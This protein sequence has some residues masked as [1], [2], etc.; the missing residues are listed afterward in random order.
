MDRSTRHP[1]ARTALAS[2][3]TSLTVRPLRSIPVAHLHV[4]FF[5]A[6]ISKDLSLRTPI[7]VARFIIDKLRAVILGTHPAPFI[8]TLPLAR[9]IHTGPDELDTPLLHR[10]YIV[11]ADKPS[12]G[13]HLLRRLAQVLFQSV[14]PRL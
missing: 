8:G 1:I 11:P 7:T 13:D 9:L 6:L 14:D 5:F 4:P 2:Y 10:Y 3:R 12:I